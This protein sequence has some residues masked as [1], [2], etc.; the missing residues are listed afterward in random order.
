MNYGVNGGGCI[1][2]S[3]QRVCTW[4]ERQINLTINLT[5]GSGR[6]DGGLVLHAGTFAHTSRK[7]TEIHIAEQ[8]VLAHKL[9]N[10]TIMSS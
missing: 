5:N 9:C 1:L 6:S 8:S 7:K 4:T 3:R 10:V 2:A